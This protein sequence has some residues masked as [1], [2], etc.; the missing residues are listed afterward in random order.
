MSDTPPSC[1]ALLFERLPDEDVLAVLSFIRRSYDQHA[2][3][4][5]CRR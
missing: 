4:L 3:S 5:T 1:S 2:V